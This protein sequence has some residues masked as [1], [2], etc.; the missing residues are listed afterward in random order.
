MRSGIPLALLSLGLLALPC[1]SSAAT[2]DCVMHYTLP[3]QCF[4]TPPPAS[5]CV[6]SMSDPCIVTKDVS[7]WTVSGTTDRCE[8]CTTQYHQTIVTWHCRAPW[9]VE[10]TVVVFTD[11]VFPDA[12]TV[13]GGCP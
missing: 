9:C 5:T 6:C 7:G 4:S 1:V 3:Q 2:C 8:V 11:L 10:K 12:C 13:A